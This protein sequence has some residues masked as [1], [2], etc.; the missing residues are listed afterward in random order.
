M[1]ELILA[2]VG[3][4]FLASLAFVAVYVTLFTV[5]ETGPAE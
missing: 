3:G 2:I 1:I 5:P 4:W